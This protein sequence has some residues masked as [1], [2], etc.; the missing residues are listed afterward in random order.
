MALWFGQEISYFPQ[1]RYVHPQKAK[2]MK[3]ILSTLQRLHKKGWVNTPSTI[4]VYKSYKA[5]KC[6]F[7]YVNYDWD[8]ERLRK[9]KTQSASFANRLFFGKLE[10][11]V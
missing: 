10:G 5:Y 4:Y 2:S 6:G 7:D 11:G 1:M 3:D 9:S 8:G